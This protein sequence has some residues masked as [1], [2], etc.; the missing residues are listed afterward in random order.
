M[1]LLALALVLSP[2]CLFLYFQLKAKMLGISDNDS[3]TMDGNNK[4]T[5]LLHVENQEIISVRKLLRNKQYL[6]TSCSHSNK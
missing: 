4:V 5:I 1:T 6:L 2:L 3:S